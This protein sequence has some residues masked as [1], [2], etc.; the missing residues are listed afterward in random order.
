[1]IGCWYGCLAIRNGIRPG[2]KP[3]PWS[4]RLRHQEEDAFARNMI[5]RAQPRSNRFP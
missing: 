2:K 1:L 4:L 3:W 5:S